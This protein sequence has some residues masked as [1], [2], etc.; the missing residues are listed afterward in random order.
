[1]LKTALLLEIEMEHAHTPVVSR[2]HEPLWRHMDRAHRRLIR[3][4]FEH[5][6]AAP[7]RVHTHSAVAA[8]RD[9]HIRNG[10]E[11]VD[12][13]PPL[14]TPPSTPTLGVLAY[15]VYRPERHAWLENV[16]AAVCTRAE[17]ELAR[18]LMAEHIIH[19]ARVYSTSL[20]TTRA[21]TTRALTTHRARCSDAFTEVPQSHDAILAA[22][23][24]AAIVGACERGGVATMGSHARPDT[25]TLE[26]PPDDTPITISARNRA[27]IERCQ[28]HH[29][30]PVL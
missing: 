18:K 10:R 21:L 29:W 30:R 13:A 15:H 8:A 16:D 22:A 3:L 24:K 28:V 4:E 14:P 23:Q 26:I 25:P 9:G 17:Y 1:M 7:N 11:C 19:R 20:T 5:E 6:L 27:A 2:A 12:K